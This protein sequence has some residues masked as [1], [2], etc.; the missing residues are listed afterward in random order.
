MGWEKPEHDGGSRLTGYM[1]E[2][3]KFGTDKWMKVASLKLTDFEHT[4][5]K[6]NEGEQYLFRV[7]AINSRGASEAKELV[8][9]VT[10]KEQRGDRHSR[11]VLIFWGLF[12]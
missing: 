6:L 5:E 10:V 12:A 2:A 3:C 9:P 11:S 8:A 7:K 1:V 4:I